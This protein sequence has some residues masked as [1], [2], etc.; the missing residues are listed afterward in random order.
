MPTLLVLISTNNS[1]ISKWR[2]CSKANTPQDVLS[3][4]ML[5]LTVDAFHRVLAMLFPGYMV[6]RYSMHTFNFTHQLHETILLMRGSPCY[7]WPSLLSIPS[8]RIAESERVPCPA[9][10]V[11][12]GRW[13]TWELRLTSSVPSQP[14]VLVQTVLATCHLCILANCARPQPLIFQLGC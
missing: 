13:H 4:W 12:S 1:P 11:A 9:P 6:S 14:I 2:A 3:F 10:T 8:S 7:P 5:H